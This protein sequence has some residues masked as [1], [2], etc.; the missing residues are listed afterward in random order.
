L[1]RDGRNVRKGFDAEHTGALRVDGKDGPAEGT[2]EEIP[3]DRA[4][5]AAG[6]FGRPDHRDRRRCDE[7]V[8]WL[9]PLPQESVG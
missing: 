9:V 8:E 5:D 6:G 7:N 2:A 4:A 1:H 3:Q